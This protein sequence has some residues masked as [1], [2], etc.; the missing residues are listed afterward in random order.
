ML[1]ELEFLPRLQLASCGRDLHPE[2]TSHATPHSL[3]FVASRP[4]LPPRTAYQLASL[5]RT[6]VC[7]VDTLFLSDCGVIYGL[8][9]D[10]G[11]PDFASMSIVDGSFGLS[12]LFA[13]VVTFRP[14]SFAI[15]LHLRSTWPGWKAKLFIE[16]TPV[17]IPMV[18]TSLAHVRCPT[19]LSACNSCSLRF[20]V[21]SVDDRNTPN[22][23]LHDNT[24]ST[25]SSSPTTSRSSLLFVRVDHR[26]LP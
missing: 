20:F 22:K 23:T 17:P 6:L 7:C 3:N 9:F 14:S 25:S 18:F 19:P 10:R 8:K 21:S 4:E 16:Q 5:S 24:T 26:C 11:N 12:S 2:E 15:R 1:E 13:L